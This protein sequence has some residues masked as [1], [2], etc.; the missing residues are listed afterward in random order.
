MYIYIYYIYNV[1]IIS[2]YSTTKIL[3]DQEL[4]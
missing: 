1:P 2:N 4:I 3:I